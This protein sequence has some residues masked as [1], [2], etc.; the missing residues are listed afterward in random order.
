MQ[1]R[2]LGRTGVQVS[3]LCFGT[4]SFGGDADEA[5]AAALF[6]RCREAGVNFFDCANVYNKGR[7]EEILGRLI[8]EA[9]CREEV[10]IT[11]KVC[12]PMG[13]DVNARG[14]SRRHVLRMVE[15]SLKRL[16]TDWIDLYF[17]HGQDPKTPMD[18][19][20]RALDDLVRQGKIL[21]AGVSNWA[22]WQ[23]AKSLG[24]SALKNIVRFECIEPMYSL[25]KRQVEVELLPL[26][27]SEQMGV[28]TYSP[29]GGGLLTGKFGVDR[30][31]ET[32]RLTVN[33]L[34]RT[35]YGDPVNYAVAD[36]LTAY[37]GARD[38]HPATL[39]VAW[40]MSHG[41]ITAPIVGARTLA[42]LVPSLAAAEFPM[43]PEMRAEL[44]ALTPEPPTATDRSEEKKGMTYQGVLAK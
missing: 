37:A 18:E 40:V 28:I 25:V 30:Q 4:M 22:A 21:Y 13:P 14:A 12:F 33:K 41:A 11:S 16:N 29:L 43:T 34:Y 44:S 31:P 15:G 5:T 27:Q 35:R 32:G 19:T 8:A 42:Q 3:S 26:A 10:V 36:R 20:L 1:Y 2:T 17:I 39:A 24:I 6:N 23:I 9:G 7:S 38:V